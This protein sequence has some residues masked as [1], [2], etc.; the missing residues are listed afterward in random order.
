MKRVFVAGGAGY[1]GSHT[2]IELLRQNHEVLVYDNLSNSSEE[3]IKRIQYLTNRKL[4]LVIGD[5]REKNKLD[6]AMSNFKPDTVMHFAALKSVAQSVQ[7]PLAYYDVNVNGSINLL[8][9]MS[10]IGCSE[11]VFSSSATVYG[12][13]NEPPYKETMAVN[14]VSPYGRTKL[15]CEE[16]L[17]DWTSSNHENW[18]VVL[19][20][21]NPLG[22]DP[23]GLIG[24]NPLDRPNNLMPLI[25]QAATK[26]RN[27]LAIFGDNYDT[28]DGTGERDYIHVSDLA[29][30]HLKAL[31]SIRDL[32]R[33]QILN[34]GTGEGTTVMELIR[35][36]EIVNEVKVLTHNAERRPGD[37][38][39]SFADPSLARK[40]I[41]FKCTKSIEEMCVDTWSWV[42]NTPNLPED[43]Q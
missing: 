3:A 41:N 31:E 6:D 39:R 9:S 14:P 21:F 15:F 22:A 2:C 8:Q 7:D 37:V 12:E 17:R 43:S 42:N 28:R 24:E 19:R 34:L 25:V 32:A 35:T 5:I 20:Y 18:A 23:S 40:L 36:F 1:I 13:D 27:R 11:M 10:R 26:K 30:G 4:K 16:I 29:Y 33:F 38:A